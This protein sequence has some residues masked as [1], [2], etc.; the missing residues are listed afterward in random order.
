MQQLCDT[1]RWDRGIERL[2]LNQTEMTLRNEKC[3]C[4]RVM[5]N[6]PR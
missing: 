3:E 1:K 4:H 5:Q 6:L 2:L